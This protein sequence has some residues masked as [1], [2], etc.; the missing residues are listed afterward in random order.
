MKPLLLHVEISKI[1]MVWASDKFALL[2]GIHA[3]WRY[4]ISHL[5]WECLGI[6]Q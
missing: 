5:T 2:V 6:T 1:E 3:A 4:Y